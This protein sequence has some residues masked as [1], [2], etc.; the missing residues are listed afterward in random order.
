MMNLPQ[1]LEL[2]ARKGANHVTRARN[3]ILR[4]AS[5]IKTPA[6]LH[7]FVQASGMIGAGTKRLPT[8]RRWLRKR[9]SATS[10][11]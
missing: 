7:P 3:L 4:T 8:A 10:T 1:H 11:N 2:L 9:R 5:S 6:L